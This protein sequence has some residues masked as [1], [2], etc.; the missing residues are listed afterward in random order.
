MIHTAE[1]Q[2]YYF[3]SFNGIKD[4]HAEELKNNCWIK[5]MPNPIVSNARISYYLPESAIIEVC[6]YDILGNRKAIIH[7]GF[8]ENGTYELVY[9]GIDDNGNSMVNGTYILSIRSDL[10]RAQEKIVIIK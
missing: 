8:H 10:Y 4:N 6:L 1:K 2:D 5:C 7:K 3:V 9:N